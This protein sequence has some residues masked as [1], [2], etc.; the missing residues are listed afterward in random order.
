MLDARRD[1]LPE[2]TQQALDV[3]V[4]QVRRFDQMVID[5]LELSRIDAGAADLNAEEV[6]LDD[7]VPRMS[8]SATASA[9]SDRGRHRRCRRDASS[10]SVRF[11]RI[12]AN[13]LENARQHGGGPT[14]ITIEPSPG[15]R[16]VLIAVE[17]AGPGVRP[18]SG[19][20]S[21]S[22]SPAAARPGIASAPGSAWRW[23]PST[24]PPSAARHGSRIARRRRPLRR[25]L[26]YGGGR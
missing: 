14:R 9:T 20:A 19:T 4:G 7:A 13:L 21:S 17:D 5:L 16:S 8:P 10:T 2:R 26:A 3:V 24:P 18:A 25:P 6:D 15:Q 22:A 11:E 1:D 23:S 12:L